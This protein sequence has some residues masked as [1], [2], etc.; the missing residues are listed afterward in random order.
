M[1]ITY[2]LERVNTFI[3]LDEYYRVARDYIK[4]LT[5]ILQLV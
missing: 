3:S 1:L 2:D 5:K 4:P